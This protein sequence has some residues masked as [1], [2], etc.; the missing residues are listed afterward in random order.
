MSIN[1]FLIPIV[2]LAILGVIVYK[3][4]KLR[5]V[6]EAFE[7][8]K[9]DLTGLQ[10]NIGK[11]LFIGFPS[12][13]DSDKDLTLLKDA[14]LNFKDK[15]KMVQPGEN[16]IIISNDDSGGKKIVNDICLGINEG[17]DTIACLNAESL[18][19][20]E[21]EKKKIPRFKDFAEKQVY[22]NHDQP[23][24]RHNKLCFYDPNGTRGVNN[25]TEDGSI[26]SGEH[27]ITSQHL[28]LMNG[29]TA[30][31][32]RVRDD[33]NFALN[34]G[35]YKEISPVNVEY[36]PLPGFSMTAV[37]PFYMTDDDYTMLRTKL[38][39]TVTC[40]KDNRKH[41]SYHS[42]TPGSAKASFIF[43]AV[44]KPMQLYSH[45]HKHSDKNPNF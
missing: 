42:Y 38:D 8:D 33:T 1:D 26:P 41:S 13:E 39:S 29:N 2:V 20:F 44:P 16:S 34:R 36:G 3:F 9:F 17:S 27:C 21:Y 28:D 24:V 35:K 30:I 37:R 19:K 32:L 31:K 43:N 7:G 23:T 40:Y 45:I 4:K 12:K 10:V 15:M 25:Y 18:E 11:N 5:S 6:K 14:K 22:Y